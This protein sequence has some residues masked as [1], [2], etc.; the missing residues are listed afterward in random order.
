MYTESRTKASVPVPWLIV[1]KSMDIQ[2]LGVWIDAV[3]VG[4]SVGYRVECSKE[5]GKLS[6]AQK[7]PEE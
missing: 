5:D 7:K 2:C 1:E 3:V 6:K 4:L